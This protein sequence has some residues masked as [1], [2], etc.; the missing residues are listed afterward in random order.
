MYCSNCPVFGDRSRSEAGWENV[1][2]NG[3]GHRL[4]IWY[5]R[6]FLY[7]DYM[8]ASGHFACDGNNFFYTAFYLVRFGANNL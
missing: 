8:Y 2:E 1:P 4:Q 6:S 7:G 3:F 5:V